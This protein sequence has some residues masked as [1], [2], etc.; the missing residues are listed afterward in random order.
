MKLRPLK[1]R[2]RNA[3]RARIYSYPVRRG[4]RAAR[5]HVHAP[6]GFFGTWRVR[7]TWPGVKTAVNSAELACGPDHRIKVRWQKNLGP[8][9]NA[10]MQ[11]AVTET[12]RRLAAGRSVCR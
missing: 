3:N 1:A 2:G 6:G 12:I 9:V 7:L 10:E 11:A 4:P 8:G 5:V